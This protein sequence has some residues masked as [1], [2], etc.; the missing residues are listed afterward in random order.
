MIKI[1]MNGLSAVAAIVA[2][3]K[4]TDLVLSRRL[5][6]V[7]WLAPFV[8]HSVFDALPLA[9]MAKLSST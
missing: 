1:L 8:V 6:V 2:A 3:V 4:W 5:A 7:A 9:T